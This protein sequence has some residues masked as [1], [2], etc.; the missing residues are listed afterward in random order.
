MIDYLFSSLLPGKGANLA[1]TGLASIMTNIAVVVGI[2]ILKPA[3]EHFHLA[4]GGRTP[5][6]L[7]NHQFFKTVPNP[8]HDLLS[9]ALDGLSTLH[10][11]VKPTISTAVNVVKAVPTPVQ[12]FHEQS[13]IAPI[14]VI[15]ACMI[16]ALVGTV[17]TFQH[18]RQGASWSSPSAA[19]SDNGDSS[20]EPYSRDSTPPDDDP[21]D[22]E[23]SGS[24]G[25]PPPVPVF[26][27]FYDFPVL[28]L[29]K[30]VDTRD[31][32]VRDEDGAPPPPPPSFPTAVEDGDAS[33][34]KPYISKWLSLTLVLSIISFI[35]KRFVIKRFF[36][37]YGK[38]QNEVSIP[39]ASE[40]ESQR[41]RVDVVALFPSATPKSVININPTCPNLLPL[42]EI[43]T[44]PESLSISTLVVPTVSFY[45]SREFLIAVVSLLFTAC[46][47]GLPCI[48]Q[49]FLDYHLRRT[50][51]FFLAPMA[52]QRRSLDEIVCGPFFSVQTCID[53]F[54]FRPSLLLVQILVPA[55]MKNPTL[56][57][58]MMLPVAMKRT[59]LL[60]VTKKLST[61]L[62]VTVKRTVHMLVPAAKKLTTLLVT[63]ILLVPMKRT[64][65]L[66]VLKK[67]TT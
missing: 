31:E 46:L 40:T 64:L 36:K 58:V 16:L 13:S 55:A 39:T 30:A 22:D 29:D 38:T 9:P 23:S 7:D 1:E 3:I 47:F 32:Q 54:S 49:Y 52:V 28:H 19:S 5:T 50:T 59:L 45:R 63:M 60:A 34:S 24:D 51:N 57:L 42:V 67:P 48:A 62:L 37:G 20:L 2:T 21:S 4:I 56:L 35:I 25:H 6:S 65:L 27:L 43:E 26:D 61:M 14:L 41:R 10:L 33:N 17:L 66:A 12:F 11:K 15:I 53:Q 18:Y 8:R 44:K